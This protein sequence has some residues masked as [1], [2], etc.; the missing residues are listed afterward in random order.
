MANE[1]WLCPE[2]CRR[3]ERH[4]IKDCLVSQN[5]LLSRRQF[6]RNVLKVFRGRSILDGTDAPIQP[7]LEADRDGE[8]GE[9]ISHLDYNVDDDEAEIQQSE[10]QFRVL[11]LDLISLM[12]TG[13]ANR[14]IQRMMLA[15]QPTR[16]KII[17]CS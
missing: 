2:N 12:K 10:D 1:Q 14:P 4:E 6:K 15:R 8:Y 9:S 7:T 16:C 17:Q 13:I 5:S 3:R 11:V